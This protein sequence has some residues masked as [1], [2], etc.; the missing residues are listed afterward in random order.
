MKQYK[1]S[2]KVLHE[3]AIINRVQAE[4]T[5]HIILK[6]ALLVLCSIFMLAFTA[7]NA[8]TFHGKYFNNLNSDG[9]TKV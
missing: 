1:P 4:A 7:A 5:N 6:F 3:K 8:Q 9:A 2:P